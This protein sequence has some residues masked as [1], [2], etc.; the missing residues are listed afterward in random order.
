MSAVAQCAGEA[1]TP[2]YDM[3]VTGIKAIVGGPST[4]RDDAMVKVS[5]AL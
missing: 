3:F 5:Q 1:F 4:T 2:Y